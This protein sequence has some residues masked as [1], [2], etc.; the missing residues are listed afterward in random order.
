MQ[1][2]FLLDET[3]MFLGGKT[4]CKENLGKVMTQ[5]I[6]LLSKSFLAFRYVSTLQ[7]NSERRTIQSYDEIESIKTIYD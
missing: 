1:L 2:N 4:I 6:A 5:K 7:D 3:K